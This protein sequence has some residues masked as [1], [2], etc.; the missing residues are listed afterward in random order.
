MQ[1]RH[2]RRC[3]SKS[4]SS[5]ILLVEAGMSGILL[6]NQA[7]SGYGGDNEMLRSVVP[8]PASLVSVQNAVQLPRGEVLR[9]LSSPALG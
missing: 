4:S 2:A 5:M 1:Q 3:R 8:L 9:K 7:R 6:V